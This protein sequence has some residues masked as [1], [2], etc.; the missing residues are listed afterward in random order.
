MGSTTYRHEVLIKGNV[1][2]AYNKAVTD[3]RA[4]FGHQQGYC[5][6]IQQSY[7]GYTILD[8]DRP[9]IGSKKYY[10]WESDVLNAVGD[11]AL[12]DGST[13]AIPLTPH[14]LR[15]ARQQYRWQHLKGTRGVTGWRFIGWAR[16]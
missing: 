1:K 8:V 5:G 4:E 2:Q 7:N 10:E 15:K 6:S 12:P 16:C 3:A 9:T 11:M 13:F 14:E